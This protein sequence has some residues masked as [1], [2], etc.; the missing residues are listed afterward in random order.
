MKA[1]VVGGAVMG[2]LCHVADG[3]NAHVDY[4]EC[5]CAG[6]YQ[7]TGLSGRE[8]FG[9]VVAESE[10]DAVL[11]AQERIP[12]AFHAVAINPF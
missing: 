1:E 11:H 6:P 2:H 4:D 12:D 7:I 10:D 9:V 8:N 5:P 3:L